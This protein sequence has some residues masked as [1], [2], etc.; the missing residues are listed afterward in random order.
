[1]GSPASYSHILTPVSASYANSFP[2]RRPNTIWLLERMVGEV[3]MSPARVV[4]H[5]TDNSCPSHPRTPT[6]HRLS[7]IAISSLE[8][9]HRAA[10]DGSRYTSEGFGSGLAGRA[11]STCQ[12]LSRRAY[13]AP[14]RAQSP[15]LLRLSTSAPVPTSRTTSSS[16][17]RPAG[18][19]VNDCVS[20]RA[21]PA[22]AKAFGEPRE[23]PPSG[24]G[25]DQRRF[26]DPSTL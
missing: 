7:V 9:C 22:K 21:C 15:R 17:R 11:A 8:P 6:W 3:W 25:W 16:D 24:N 26:P 4:S 2:S 18:L 1:M 12:V 20:A 5:R 14:L 23:M 13:D 19:P 10:G